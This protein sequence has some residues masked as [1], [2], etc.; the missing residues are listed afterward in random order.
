VSNFK[1]HWSIDLREY[2]DK[3]GQLAPTQRGIS[4]PP[5]QW[6]KLCAGLGSLAAG[7]EGGA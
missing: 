1:G 5:E 4:L 6:A 2:Y 3:D 7:L